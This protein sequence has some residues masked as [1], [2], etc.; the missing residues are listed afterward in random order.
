MNIK[1]DNNDCGCDYEQEQ[2]KIKKY[3]KN[4]SN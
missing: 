2:E 4:Y 1:P 3:E